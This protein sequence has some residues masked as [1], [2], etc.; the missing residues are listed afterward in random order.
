MG[1]NNVAGWDF[2]AR[3]S[4]DHGRASQKALLR[5]HEETKW[6]QEQEERDLAAA[7]AASLGESGGASGTE[8][9][10]MGPSAAAAAAKAAADRR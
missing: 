5:Q 7:I 4:S 3:V 8:L 10:D 1:P 9:Q 2:N 6:Q